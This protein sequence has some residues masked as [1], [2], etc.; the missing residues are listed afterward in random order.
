MESRRSASP[1]DEDFDESSTTGSDVSLSEFA[2]YQEMPQAYAF[3]PKYTD[4]ELKRLPVL[5]EQQTQTSY[6]KQNTDW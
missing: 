3:H 6:R 4:D 5:M 2:I 1:E